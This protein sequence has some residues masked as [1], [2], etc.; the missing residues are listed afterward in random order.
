MFSKATKL[1]VSKFF[2][3]NSEVEKKIRS[4]IHLGVKFHSSGSFT[5]AKQNIYNRGITS[6]F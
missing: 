3:N 2:Y 1:D 4:Y 6:V 5:E